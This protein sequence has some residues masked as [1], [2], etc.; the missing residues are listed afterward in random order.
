MITKV[1]KLLH[2]LGISRDSEDS[3]RT[4]MVNMDHVCCYIFYA[5]LCTVIV[6][7]E[8]AR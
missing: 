1:G 6:I 7:E 5:L 3:G 4:P 2:A 8:F